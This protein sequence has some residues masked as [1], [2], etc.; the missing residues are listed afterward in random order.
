M[1]ADVHNSPQAR[2][3]SIHSSA[4]NDSVSSP[5]SIVNSLSLAS[6][7]DWQQQ[8]LK[9][10]YLT[11]LPPPQVIEICLTFEPH[12]PPHIKS[13]VWPV[14]ISASISALE[15]P[16]RAPQP[17]VDSSQDKASAVPST[18]PSPEMSSRPDHGSATNDESKSAVAVVQP[19][20]PSSASQISQQLYHGHPYPPFHQA[21]HYASPHAPFPSYLS[22]PHAAMPP[23]RPPNTAAT[24]RYHD[25]SGSQ[26]GS[27]RLPQHAA[28]SFPDLPVPLD[29]PPLAAEDL[30]SY[31]EMIVE[32][33]MDSDDPEGCVPKTV[34]NWMATHYPLQSNF[35]PSASQA[36]QKAFKRGRLEKF[37]GGKYR[38]NASWGGGRVS[39]LCLS[40]IYI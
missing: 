10:K 35:R 26:P 25:P 9:R 2:D 14:D 6:S 24:H 29:P 31:E 1:Q 12:V 32:A 36:L 7:L 15:S 39:M 3:Q 30:P 18:P 33:L 13:S 34:F 5:D 19:T 23:P 8:S 11:L 22:H 21:T 37:P 28:A 20:T 38:L 16:T 4:Q 17:A 27:S 40:Y